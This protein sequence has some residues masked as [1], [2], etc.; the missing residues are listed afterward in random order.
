M[1]KILFTLMALSLL[2]NAPVYAMHHGEKTPEQKA[3]YIEKKV[4]KMTNALNLSDDQ[5]TKYEAVL[6]TKMDKKYAAQ[7]K[8]NAEMEG[9][10]DEYKKGVKGI[11]NADQTAK[12]DKMMSK[13]ESK[14]DKKKKKF[15]LF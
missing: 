10:K 6:K 1:K 7:D 14:K 2:A 11:L 8:L 13:Y 4:E 3:K 5:K 15:L 12:F 9:I